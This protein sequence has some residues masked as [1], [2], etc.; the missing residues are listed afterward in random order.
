MNSD[1][2]TWGL[3]PR[4]AGYLFGSEIVSGVRLS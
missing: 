3:S 2:D 4:G 1:I